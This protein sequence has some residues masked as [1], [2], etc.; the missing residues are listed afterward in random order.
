MQRTARPRPRRPEEVRGRRAAYWGLGFVVLLL[1][2][3]G[4]VTVPGDR[5]SVA[6]VRDFYAENG[7]VVLVAQV[8]G[9][10]AAAAFLAFALRLQRA[11]GIAG[12]RPWVLVSGI[13]VAAAAALTAVPPLLLTREAESGSADTVAN[14]ARAS[15]LTDVLLF[16][17]IGAF[18]AAVAASVRVVWVRAVAAIAGL[19]SLARAALLLVG[20]ALLEVVAPLAFIVLVLGLSWLCWRWSESVRR[21]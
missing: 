8:I 10:L 15:D 14:L 3:A 12:D 9:L 6:F 13:A 1:V 2:S 17:A 18:G 11:S 5:D 21:R 16:A 4:M 19:A 20:S 7:G